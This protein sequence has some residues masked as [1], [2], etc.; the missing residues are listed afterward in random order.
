MMPTVAILDRCR[1]DMVVSSFRF[2]MKGQRGT[3]RLRVLLPSGGAL[4]KDMLASL[5]LRQMLAFLLMQVGKVFGDV[6][7]KLGGNAM[8]HFANL[9]DGFVGGIHGQD[10]QSNSG[11]VTKSGDFRP[12]FRLMSRMWPNLFALARWRQFH[13]TR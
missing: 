11:G 12:S 9:F 2:V 4:R 6:V 8:T 3:C 7:L 5:E 10:S 13:V 1:S